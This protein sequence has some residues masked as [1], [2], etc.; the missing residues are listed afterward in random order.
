MTFAYTAEVNSTDAFGKST[1]DTSGWSFVDL[2]SVYVSTRWYAYSPP[3]FR[4]ELAAD[5]EG[6]AADDE[7]VYLGEYSTA[8]YEGPN[9]TFTYV[10]P[11]STDPAVSSSTLLENV[12]EVGRALDVGAV[13]SSV[14]AFVLPSPPLRRGGRAQ[15]ASFWVDDDSDIESS[16]WYHEYVHT[17]QAYPD[18]APGFVWFSEG[19]ADYYAGYFAWKR[20]QWSD[21]RFHTYLNT[22]QDAS[23]VLADVEGSS[24]SASYTK[25]RRVL[26][27]LDGEIRVATDGQRSLEDAFRALNARTDDNVTLAEFEATVED[28]S[29][30]QFDAWFDRYVEGD[31]VPPVPSLDVYGPVVEAAFSVSPSPADPNESV[32]LDASSSS[33]STGSL[34]AYRWDVDGDGVTDA[35]GSVLTRAFASTQTVTL[36]VET[37][38]GET[39]S[40]SKTVQVSA[41][42]TDPLAEFAGEDGVVGT[43]ELR[44]VISRWVGGGVD[45]ETLRRAITYWVSATRVG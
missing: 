12:S 19:S 28:V 18:P 15:A 17:R 33:V 25:G 7:F 5:G 22:T 45:T 23:A 9:Q 40:V 30:R 38:D 20:G 36:T 8:T 26:A 35:N 43:S 6:Y 27:A 4:R 13:D 37:A 32:T 39:S 1:V 42:T 11:A 10:R 24:A 31:D 3:G 21:R 14:T 29:G 2:R 16:V 41:E 34:V 44:T